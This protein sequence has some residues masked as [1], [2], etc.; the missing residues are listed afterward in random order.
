MM[1]AA[2][3]KTILITGASGFV[4]THVVKAF[5]EHGYQV[6][7]TVRSEQTAVNVRK[8]FLEYSDRLSFT[9][10]EDMAQPGAFDEAVRGVNGVGFIPLPLGKRRVDKLA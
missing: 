7:G 9:I 8:T 3:D 6:R 1:S 5:L 4:A 10:V 2:N